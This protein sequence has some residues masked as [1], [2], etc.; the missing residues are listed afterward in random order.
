MPACTS[1]IYLAPVPGGSTTRRMYRGPT[2][3][4]TI[5][6]MARIYLWRRPLPLRLP[7]FARL[8]LV[9][10]LSWRLSRPLL[11]PESWV[12][13]SGSPS[14]LPA[15]RHTFHATPSSL[16]PSSIRHP[17]SLPSSKL[18]LR[19]RACSLRLASTRIRD[20]FPPSRDP[21]SCKRARSFYYNT[22]PARATTRASLAR[23]PQL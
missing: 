20:S 14:C 4:Q 8:H 23:L 7:L 9:L 15:R 2:S 10:S 18:S 6:G 16:L 19:I 1:T 21:R 5:A 11:S 17:S 22:L 12:L 13:L 3:P